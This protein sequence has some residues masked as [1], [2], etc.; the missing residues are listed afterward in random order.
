MLARDIALIDSLCG[1]YAEHSCLEFKQDNA[2]P[3]LI[4]KL[5]SALLLMLVR[6]GTHE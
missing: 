4:G 1:Q 5:C 6:E 2:D 3:K